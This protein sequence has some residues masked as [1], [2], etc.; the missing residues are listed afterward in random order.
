MFKY[1]ILCVLC[2]DLC[3]YVGPITCIDVSTDGKSMVTGS[4]DRCIIMWNLN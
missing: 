2:F 4:E 1:V 3:M